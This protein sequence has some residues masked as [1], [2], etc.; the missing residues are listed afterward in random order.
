MRR[1][2]VTS[3]DVLQ[4][5]IDKAETHTHTHTLIAPKHWHVSQQTK[6]RRGKQLPIILSLLNG[7]SLQSVYFQTV[8]A[9][10]R[11]WEKE[12]CIKLEWL[13]VIFM[14]FLLVAALHPHIQMTKVDYTTE[15]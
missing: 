8:E 6:H 5:F 3:P 14:S 2:S 7:K 11:S 15:H 13:H 12:M 1:L 10:L 9:F 4:S